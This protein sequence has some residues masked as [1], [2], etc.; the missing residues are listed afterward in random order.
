METRIDGMD[1]RFETME[2]P[3]DG[4]DVR[5]DQVDGRLASLKNGQ[6]RLQ[7]KLDHVTNE[8]WRH[9]KH[10]DGKLD[11]HQSIFKLVADDVRMSF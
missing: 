11:M 6:E 7:E 10:V 8:T 9:F 2:Q 3:F 5:F 1:V 4:M